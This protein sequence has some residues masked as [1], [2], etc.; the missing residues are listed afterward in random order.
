MLDPVP[1]KE[2]TV[3]YFNGKPWTGR[4]VLIWLSVLIGAVILGVLAV[5]NVL[6]SWRCLS[7]PFLLW[8]WG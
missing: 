1:R 2:S 7:C 4:E 6:G 3:I 8:A 5:T